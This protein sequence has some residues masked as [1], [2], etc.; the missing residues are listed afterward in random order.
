[1]KMDS[2]MIGKIVWLKFLRNNPP[3]FENPS[4]EEYRKYGFVSEANEYEYRFTLF[5]DPT[6]VFIVYPNEKGT[7]W[8]YEN[9][10]G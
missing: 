1:M 10:N 3:Y 4:F 7:N 6:E 5:D 9:G 2:E 8:D